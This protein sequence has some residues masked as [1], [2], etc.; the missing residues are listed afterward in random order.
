MS[1]PFKPLPDAIPANRGE[2][3]AAELLRRLRP[4]PRFSAAAS[5]RI[6]RAV[7]GVA[8]GR[9]RRSRATLGLAAAALA[10]LVMVLALPRLRR[11]AQVDEGG[12]VGFR[13]RGPAAILAPGAAELRIF[14]IGRDGA[15]PL[16]GILGRDEELAFAYHGGGTDRRLLV[17]ARDEH[18]H[19]YWY[20]PAWTEPAS[21]PESI[22]L[23]PTPGLHE[24]PAAIA[25]AL[26]GRRLE[27]CWLFTT[28]PL[29]ARQ[30]E[31]AL[32]R[33]ELAA[34]CRSVEVTP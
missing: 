32:G 17:F 14:R 18:A 2:A 6:D 24:L 29:R 21:D 22:A 20:H 33:G 12:G 30:V 19:V 13:A 3:R 28:E 26:D 34:T 23:D 5:A 1:S 4:P 27:L 8:N 16:Q 10:G 9:V 7:A 15:Q 25:H 31:A 11:Q